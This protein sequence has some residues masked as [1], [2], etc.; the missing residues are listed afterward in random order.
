MKNYIEDIKNNTLRVE[1]SYRG[2]GIEIDV[3]KILGI[4]GAKMSAYQNYLGGGILGSIQSDYNFTIKGSN[5]ALRNKVEALEDQLKEYYFN[6]RNE[7]FEDEYN[8]DY[9][10][11][12]SRSASAY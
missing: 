5:K 10:E 8:E 4:N 7:E 3:S 11:I 1:V 6:L 2:G 9:E 12:Q